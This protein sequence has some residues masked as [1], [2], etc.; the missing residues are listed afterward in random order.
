MVQFYYQYFMLV[1]PIIQ[2]LHAVLLDWWIQNC[3]CHIL[4]RR[5]FLFPVM[6]KGHLQIYKKRNQLWKC[7]NH[8]QF[9]FRGGR[10]KAIL[11][12]TSLQFTC[13]N[14]VFSSSLQELSSNKAISNPCLEPCNKQL[15]SY[16]GSL[17]YKP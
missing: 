7:Y 13:K 6:A 1:H 12:V 10:V 16:P 17:Q 9:Y 2:L 4:V 8:F 3:F 14:N 5:V 11:C 15:S